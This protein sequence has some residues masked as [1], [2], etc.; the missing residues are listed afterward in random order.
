MLNI[1]KLVGGTSFGPYPKANHRISTAIENARYPETTEIMLLIMFDLLETKKYF[2]QNHKS[3]MSGGSREV[4][5]KKLSFSKIVYIYYPDSSGAHL[6]YSEVFFMVVNK[7][8]FKIYRIY[9]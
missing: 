3:N 4:N 6:L 1:K 8:G 7:T 2:Y 9:T 5:G